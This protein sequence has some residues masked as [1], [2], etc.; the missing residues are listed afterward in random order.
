MLVLIWTGTDMAAG[1]QQK[2]RSL[3]FATNYTLSNTLTVQIAKF[4]E[5]SH[6]FNQH[7]SSLVRHVN[8]A[9]NDDDN[10]LNNNLINNLINVAYV[11]GIVLLIR[12][13]VNK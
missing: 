4:P 2:H 6:L 7:S 11:S 12:D 13:T 3:S 8:A 10:E 1:N 5:V 9:S